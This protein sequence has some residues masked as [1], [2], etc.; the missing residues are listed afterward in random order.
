MKK[1]ITINIGNK[2]AI[3]SVLSGNKVFDTFFLETFSQETLPQ[4]LDFFKK[5]KGLDTIIL[6]DTVAQNY[7]YKIF[8]PLSYFDLQEMVNRK[9]NTEIPKNDL[10]Q[11]KLLYKNSLDKRSVYLFV[12]ASTDSPLKEWLNFFNIVP[13]NLIGIYMVPLEAEEIAK[14]IMISNGMKETLKK[15]NSWILIIFNNRASDLRQVAVFNGN[16]A[17]T[18]LISF[19]P[20][21]ENLVDF[22]K[23][24]IIRTS[25]YIKRFDT[26]FNFDKLVIITVLDPQSK[27]ALRELKMEKTLFL[28]Y[29]P[30]EV[31]RIIKVGAR[32]INKDEKYSD[33]LI[34]MFALHNKKN[35]KFGNQKIN[36]TNTLTKT[37]FAVKSLILVLI[38]AIVASFAFNIITSSSS[39]KTLQDLTNELERNNTILKSKTKNNLDVNSDEVNQIIEAGLLKDILD[40]KYIN[41]VDSFQKFA[42]A[43]NGNALTF[44]LRWYINNFDYQDANG[45]KSAKSLY[46]I[47]IINPEGTASKLFNKYDMVNL[48]LKDTFKDQMTGITSLPN[49]INF[50]QKYLTYPIKVEII[51]QG[52]TSKNNNKN[53][54]ISNMLNNTNNDNYNKNYNLE[55][56]VIY[57]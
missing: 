31:S 43:Q 26:E 56:G 37:L 47:S 1:I 19:D 15:K 5:H 33:L 36:I 34:S 29:T 16:I 54:Y 45:I 11:K 25:E 18:R 52:S 44:S 23:S 17:F 30:S 7:N 32:Y 40:S 2:G 24:D 9:F 46:D 3:L 4:V 8:P 39:N 38:L 14:K 53:S 10:K 22:T 13:N 55:D 57:E 21:K 27:T 51:E 6:L 41:P 20:S 28:N 49:N 48:K 50:S 12:S 35:I 42:K